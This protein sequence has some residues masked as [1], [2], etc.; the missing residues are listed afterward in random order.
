MIK[1]WNMQY[2]DYRNV[3]D[4][5]DQQHSKCVKYLLSKL[6]SIHLLMKSLYM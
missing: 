5:L 2:N 3:I 6:L 4:T 1:Y